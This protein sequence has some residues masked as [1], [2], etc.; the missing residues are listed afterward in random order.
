MGATTG[1]KSG[2]RPNLDILYG[3]FVD[4]EARMDAIKNIYE[5]TKME[6]ESYRDIMESMKTKIKKQESLKNV[7]EI[8]IAKPDKYYKY[9][10]ETKRLDI[11]HDEWNKIQ[12][13]KAKAAAKKAEEKA[14]KDKEKAD[15]EKADAEKSEVK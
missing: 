7:G 6:Y 11:E 9:E 15:T 4:I 13:D 10:V 8:D 2:L 3:D 1:N 14:K 12:E 5:A